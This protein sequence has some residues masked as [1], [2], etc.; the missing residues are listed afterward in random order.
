MQ[1]FAFAIIYHL[2]WLFS[3]LPMRILYILS[4]FFFLIIYYLIKYRRKVVLQ[5]ISYAF[6]EKT[7]K[8]KKQIAKQFFKHFADLFV[9]SIKSFSISKN[10]VLKRYKYKN[11]ELINEFVQEGRSIAL[12]GAH[13]A[14][15]EWSL[16]LPL[17]FD[18]N[19]FCAYKKLKNEFFEKML[20]DVREKFGGIGIKTHR[21]VKRIFYNHTNNI[22]G[23]YILLS[24]QSP[25]VERTLYWTEFFGVKVPVHSGPEILAKKFDLV[26]L[27]YTT[28]KIKR[29]Y[30][31]T[32]F[33]LITDNPKKYK[34]YE[35]TK[36]Y[37]QL[38]EK[39]IKEQPQFYLWS[40]NRF[41]HQHRFEEWQNMQI[42]KQQTKK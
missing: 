36:K 37:I 12:V 24:D 38:T 34:N 7:E 31:E 13:Q 21:A 32:E 2:I 18:V 1:S 22:Q 23:I 25:L 29:G 10:E 6:P 26:F 20:K 17:L 9:E 41:K 35:I 33:E 16:N 8:E 27:N 30:Y 15:W 5:N 19:V 39:K 28:K 14:N 40:H 42:A 3:K 11:L 4:D